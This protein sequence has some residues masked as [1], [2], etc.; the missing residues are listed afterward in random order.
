MTVV[1]PSSLAAP[2][3]FEGSD[4]V[5]LQR[6]PRRA[7]SRWLLRLALA[8]PFASIAILASSAPE[9]ADLRRIGP[10]HARRGRIRDPG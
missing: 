8:L 2:R 6:F 9:F 7:R 5:R 4:Q 1:S 10:R 3:R